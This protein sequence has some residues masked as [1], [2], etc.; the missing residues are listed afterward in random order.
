VHPLLPLFLFCGIAASHSTA[1]PQPSRPNGI[2]IM[3]DDIGHG[4]V[5]CY[6]ATQVKT[7]NLDRLAKDGLRLTD[8][9]AAS[10]TCE[11]QNLYATRPEIVA[12]LA[13]LREPAMSSGRTAP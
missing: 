1:A 3:A 6:G 9:H 5:S 13:A 12:E 2:V 4:N 11:T 10:A 8:G 7:P